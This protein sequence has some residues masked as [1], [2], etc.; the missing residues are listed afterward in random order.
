MKIK[1]NLNFLKPRFLNILLT[2]VVFSS[3][4]L[5]E[6]ARLPD[7]AITETVY[8]RPIFLITSYSNTGLVSILFNGW[9]FPCYLL[10]CFSNCGYSCSCL[11]EDL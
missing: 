5:R 4:L 1:I 2:L 8:Y 11:E 9:F 7:G 3:P 6:R 10:C